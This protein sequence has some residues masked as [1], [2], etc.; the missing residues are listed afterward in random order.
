MMKRLLFLSLAFCL[1]LD[2][3]RVPD[4]SIEFLKNYSFIYQNEQGQ[5]FFAGEWVNDSVSILANNYAAEG[6]E[7]VKVLFE[8]I[9]GAGSVTKT[10]VVTNIN[11][12]ASTKWQLGTGSTEQILRAKS[13]DMSGKY[14]TSSDL[15]AYGFRTGEWNK[16]SG[17][18]DGG[19]AGMIADTVNKVTL[20]VNSNSVYKPGDRYYMWNEVTDPLLV[21]SRTISMDGN[22]VIYVTTWNGDLVKSSDHG[23]TWKTCTK[24][25]PDRPYYFFFSVANDNWLWAFYFDHHTRYSSDGGETWTDAGGGIESIGYGDV[26]RLEDGSLIIHGSNCC[27]LNRSFDNGLSWTSIPSPGYSL[28]LYVNEKDE[29]FIVTQVDTGIAIYRSTDNGASFSPVHTVFPEWGTAMY[30]T[31]NK[32]R[33]FYYVLIPG[34]GILKSPDLIHYEDYYLNS[35]LLDLFIDQNGVMVAKAQDFHTVYYMKNGSGE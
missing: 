9:K 10:E 18:P 26:F 24:P 4:P 21:S 7:P 14:L 1:F 5:R 11:G 12:I 25:Y 35:D 17:T 16:W 32:W 20:M 6:R 19:M 8:V 22:G 29:I 13:Y 28:K 2:C 30:N 23:Q 34:Y 15:R 27:S 33:S 31:F 3:D